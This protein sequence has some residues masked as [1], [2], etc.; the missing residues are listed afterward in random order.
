M[1]IKS[2]LLF[3]FI[4]NSAP[5]LAVDAYFYQYNKKITLTPLPD[6]VRS[7]TVTSP[8]QSIQY[9]RTEEGHKVGVYNKIIVKFHMADDLD[10]YLLLSPYDVQIEKQLGPQLY[11]LIT[12]SNQLTIDLANRLSEQNFIEYAQPDFIKQYQIR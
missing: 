12:P 8:L 3:I 6:L 2:A 5:A 4:F 10:P 7:N 9:Y 1:A 11:L